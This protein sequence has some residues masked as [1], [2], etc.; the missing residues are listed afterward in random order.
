MNVDEAYANSF[1]ALGYENINTEEL[2]ALK[3]LGVKQE[4]IFPCGMHT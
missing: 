4:K 1:K 3:S 2:V